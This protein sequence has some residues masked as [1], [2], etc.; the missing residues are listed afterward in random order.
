MSIEEDLSI[1]VMHPEVYEM[2]VE[3]RSG[4]CEEIVGVEVGKKTK[5]GGTKVH[6][7]Q[8]SPIFSN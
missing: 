8:R 5:L 2:S 1:I 6:A 3:I 4:N 7:E